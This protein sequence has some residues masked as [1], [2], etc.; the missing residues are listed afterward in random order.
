MY[1]LRYL[2]EKICSGFTNTGLF[3]WDCG[4][5]LLDHIL[6][7]F[8]AVGNFVSDVGGYIFDVLAHRKRH[9]MDLLLGL[10]AAILAIVLVIITTAGYR[11]QQSSSRLYWA[12]GEEALAE[13]KPETAEI[14]LQKALL[15]RTFDRNKVT[16]ALAR[17]Y[18]KMGNQERTSV[19]MDSIAP[20]NGVGNPEAHLYLATQMAAQN[21]EGKPVDLKAWDWHI[22]NADKKDPYFLDKLRSDYY[23]AAGDEQK[24]LEYITKVAEVEPNLWFFVAQRHMARKNLEAAQAALENA[25]TAFELL[26]QADQNNL[27]KRL[28]YATALLY[29]KRAGEARA[30]VWQAYQKTRDPRLGVAMSNVCNVEADQELA[31][32][33]TIERFEMAKVAQFL[34]EAIALTPNHPGTLE[35]IGKLAVSEKEVVDEFRSAL[36]EQIAK[37]VANEHSFYILGVL[38]YQAGDVQAAQ[39]YTRQ[40]LQLVP[41]MQTAANNLAYYIT[42]SPQPNLD[43]ALTLAN[44]ACNGNLQLADFFDTRGTVYEMR[45]ELEPAITDYLKA[46]QLPGPPPKLREKLAELY[47]KT[48]DKRLADAMRAQEAALNKGSSPVRP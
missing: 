31:R 13:D 42:Q 23:L 35:R 30:L 48:G 7:A 10:P 4:E 47:D 34:T 25:R 33:N 45:G 22:K 16:L 21:A 6:P 2:W 28:Q 12:L 9:W 43:E 11:E 5:W 15:T 36:A 40:A 46:L 37:G 3:L 19:L 26:W 44:T 27:E 17:T 8:S 38:E 32:R 24:S 18:E 41:T 20:V 29:T 39:R 14:Y 1:W